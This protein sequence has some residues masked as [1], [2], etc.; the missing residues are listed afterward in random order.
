MKIIGHRGAAGYFPENTLLGIKKAIFLKVNMVE[1]DV[2]MSKDGIVILM[3]DSKLDRT[4]DG[5]G[6][7]K[8]LNFEEIRKLNA[9][10]YFTSVSF[11]EKVPTLDEVLEFV[12]GKV[13]LLIEIKYGDSIYPGIEQKIIDLIHKH[14]AIDWCIV[15]SFRD[16]VL[17]RIHR[18]DRSIRIHK[19]LVWKFKGLPIQYDIRLSLFSFSKYSFVESFNVFYKRLNPDFISNIHLQGNTVY[20]WTV[21]DPNDIR[22]MKTM[23][24]DGIISDFPDRCY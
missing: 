6:A 9:A 2:Q 22:K 17:F 3:H 13:E 11:N 21:N 20:V 8:N 19:L 23:G 18:L 14:K 10:A 15:Q 7:L 24:V 5:S 1:I 16:D 12:N 4:T